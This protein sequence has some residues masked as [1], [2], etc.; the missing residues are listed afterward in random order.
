MQVEYYAVECRREW[1]SPSIA[2]FSFAALV[3]IEVEVHIGLLEGEVLFV[4]IER[5]NPLEKLKL[6]EP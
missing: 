4:A 2:E 5:W 1:I 3:P 6:R